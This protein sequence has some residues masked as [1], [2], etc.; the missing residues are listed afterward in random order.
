MDAGKE[1]IEVSLQPLT[2]ENVDVLRDLNRS[3][4][5]VGYS[6]KFY[7]LVFTLPTELQRI[8]YV[9]SGDMMVPVGSICC[10]VDSKVNM[11]YIMTLNILPAYRGRSLGSG[12]VKYVINQ[13]KSG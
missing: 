11:L 12:L 3:T 13:V 6:E 8:C 9:K 7:K 4:L 5:A 2:K 1:N 10:R